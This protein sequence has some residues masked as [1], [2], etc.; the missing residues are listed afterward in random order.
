MLGSNKIVQG[1]WV[2]ELNIL[3]Y[4]TMKSH[5][6]NRHIFHLYIYKKHFNLN[7]KY[8]PNGVILK[9]ASE[10]FEYKEISTNFHHMYATLS[11]IFRYK[12]LF[13][14]GGIWVDMDVV[15]VKPYD[16]KEDYVFCGELD[17]NNN[18]IFNGG[19]IKA[20]KK[21]KL[22]KDCYETSLKLIQ[23]ND[24]ISN[25]LI[26]PKLINEKITEYN[27][28]HYMIKSDNIYPYNPKDF[29]DM[30]S[31]NKIKKL[32]YSIHLWNELFRYYKI[33][34]KLL[35]DDKNILIG[36]I[37]GNL[38]KKYFN[39]KINNKMNIFDNNTI[40]TNNKM[41]SDVEVSKKI[42]NTINIFN[43]NN[44]IDINN[45]ILS[46]DEF[47]KKYKTKNKE[48]YKKYLLE[49]LIK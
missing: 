5:L 7:S 30:F 48:K 24:I 3:C 44:I 23:N 27:M 13:D 12:L 19:F 46:G 35:I 42:N 1:F 8:L 34:E 33:D 32:K 40:T 28:K 10:I 37:M 4:L 49:R 9:D 6:E 11:D 15:N 39:K 38:L 45:K 22:M 25:G 43:D 18:F 36:G 2:G 17:T 26:G 31:D 14:K 47:S 20:K 41:L 16:F 21:S 29:K